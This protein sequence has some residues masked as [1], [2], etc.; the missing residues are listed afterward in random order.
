SKAGVLSTLV[1]L[2]VSVAVIVSVRTI[3][4]SARDEISDQMHTLGA[5]LIILPKV[6]P[7]SGYYTADF[8][9]EVI[10][11]DYIH[12]LTSSELAEKIHHVIPKLS[13]SYEIQAEKL[14]LTGV[15]P[16]GEHQARPE[17]RSGG[18]SL[19]MSEKDGDKEAHKKEK[20]EA[21]HQHQVPSM[22]PEL[23][24]EA[25]RKARERTSLE[26][27]EKGEVF[28]GNE[29]SRLLGK[30]KGDRLRIGPYDFEVVKVLEEIGSVDDIR[31][32]VHLHQAQEILGK[33]RVI[34]AIEL[35]GC[36][37]KQDMLL[38]AGN[39]EK[40]LPGVRTRTITQIAR[41]QA[42]T[43]R[44]IER[45]TFVILFVV[46]VVAGGLISNTMTSNVLERHREI[47]VLMA[48]GASSRFI[49]LVFIKK[50]VALGFFGGLL[51]FFIGTL[52]AAWIGPKLLDL[53]IE[54]RGEMLIWTL[55]GTMVLTVVFSWI[56]S[57]R[58]TKS[59]PAALLM[60]D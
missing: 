36:G 4:V 46:L 10:P 54:P 30:S 25:S 28:L 44:L 15:L 3:T 47:G 49:F 21:P 33:G 60:E 13:S 37:C 8:G 17:W 34:N 39:I 59:D 45:F 5:N 56:P 22:T 43:V 2:M 20:E 40:L 48:I 9:D 14:I 58:A 16:K 26:D 42:R 29:S 51:G 57:V 7:L 27:I 24:L 31:V 38:L 1:A 53:N 32:F 52:S 18:L 19:L 23:S 50:A 12:R 11:E 35:I 41:T 6:A 55:L